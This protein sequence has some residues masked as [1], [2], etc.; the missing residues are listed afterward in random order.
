MIYSGFNGTGYLSLSG[1]IFA[2]LQHA[3]KSFSDLQGQTEH[4]GDHKTHFTPNS[5]RSI[6]ST[7]V[8]LR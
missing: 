2:I 4:L 1:F 5:P 3:D 8:Y 6:T 7:F